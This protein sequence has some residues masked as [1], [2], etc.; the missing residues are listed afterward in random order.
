M[1]DDELDGQIAEIAELVP[2]A[3][4]EMTAPLAPDRLRAVKGAPGH[5]QNLCVAD[6]GEVV[7]L[8]GGALL[9]LMHQY[10]AAAATY[11]L[12]DEPD[13]PRP[14]SRWPAA[15]SA[16]AVS[17]D[18]VDSAS[19]APRFPAVDLTARQAHAAEVFA[20]YAYRFALCRQL[21]HVVAEHIQRPQG[22]PRTVV[23]LR[24]SPEQD[25]EA[26]AMAVHM[27]ASSLPEDSHLS[28]ALSCSV[29][30]LTLMAAVEDGSAAFDRRT[31][32]CIAAASLV[33][34]AAEQ[35]LQVVHDD[36]QRI[37]AAVQET[38]QQERADVR[39]AVSV[40]TADT[41]L[42]PY[43]RRSPTGVLDALQ[44]ADDTA[45]LAQ[46][47]DELAHAVRIARARGR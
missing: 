2:F 25:R 8:M 29:Y 40:A 3:R 10:T 30:F 17:L 27:Q 26:D 39:A 37:V 34:P 15:R 47:P 38:R 24:A 42:E 28:T 11:F 14:S 20:H 6:R 12:P 1:I 7:I 46:L 5:V 21:A 35:G 19:T 31:M 45:L 43:L 22:D 4:P 16:L 23:V 13:G 9:A 36:L 33:H 32:T 44:A 41:A 18:W